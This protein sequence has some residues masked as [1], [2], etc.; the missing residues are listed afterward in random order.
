MVLAAMAPI[1]TALAAIL[2]E[3]VLAT[4]AHGVLED[5]YPVR[6][7]SFAGGVAGLADVVYSQPSGFR[8]LTL[9]L[10]LPSAAGK[11]TPVLHPLVLFL[12]GG[13]W[14]VG[15]TRHSGAFENWPKVLAA[16][17]ARG[18]VVSSMNYR[19]S[20]EAP[21]PA[22]IQDVK[23]AIRFLRAHA[24]EYG[25]DKRRVLVWGGSA[26]GQLAALAATSCNVAALAPPNAPAE[27]DCVQAALLWYPYTDMAALPPPS[28]ALPSAEGR[29]L[30]CEMTACPAE[31]LR[32]ASPALQVTAE[33]PPMLI[34]HGEEDTVIP[35]QQSRTLD[36]ALRKA[37]VQSELLVLAG[38]GHQFVGVTAQ[39]THEASIRALDRSIEFIDATVGRR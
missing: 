26:G 15:H 38:I 14:F 7:V 30:G 20:R 29:Y 18:Y 25:I 22:A 8:P 23:M 37:G 31:L 16:L 34:I 27:S 17:A 2:P 10:Y 36:A 24:E 6:R 1:G 28:G 21:F 13:A 5:R 12:H 19:F 3:S 11:G 4:S 33:T 35:V 32:L 9:D 39:A